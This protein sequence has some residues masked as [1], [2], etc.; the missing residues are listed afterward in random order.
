MGG[1]RRAHF[2][3]AFFPEI[4]SATMAIAVIWR[5][6]IFPVLIGSF[7]SINSR[8]IDCVSVVSCRVAALPPCRVAGPGP[9]RRSFLGVLITATTPPVITRLIARDGM[10]YCGGPAAY[11]CHAAFA[12]CTRQ[13]ASAWPAQPHAPHPTAPHRQLPRQRDKPTAFLPPALA[14]F[15]EL[16]SN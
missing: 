6:R 16:N 1:F 15:N 13:R 14:Q 11:T 4:T 12:I 8:W 10:H 5:P 3:G 2:H 9:N 7:T